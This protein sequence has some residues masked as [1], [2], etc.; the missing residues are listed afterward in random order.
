MIAYD[1]ET[2]NIAKGT[3]RPLYITAFGAQGFYVSASIDSMEHLCSIIIERF[4]IPEN[5]RCRFVA[6][7]GNNFDA[8][9]IGAAMLHSDEYEIRPYLTRSKALRGFRIVSK[10]D[11]KQNWEFLDGIAMTGLIGRKLDDFLAIFAPEFRKLKAP[12]W[13][14]GAKFDPNNA[15]HRRYAERD[16]E[17]LYWALLKAENIV[18]ETFGVPLQPTVGNMGIRIFQRNLPHG[19]K[20]WAPPLHVVEIIRDYAMRGG[21]CF[22]ARKYAGPVWKYDLNQAYAAAMRE[23]DLPT[24][25]VYMLAEYDDFFPVAI[26]RVT[27]FNPKNRIPFYY[28]AM[29][30]G[31][32]VFGLDG[33][34]ETWLTSI[35]VDQLLD[36]GW[37]VDVTEG[38]GWEFGFRMTEYVDRLEHLRM[39]A[40]GGPNGALGLL[41]KAVGNNSYGKTVEILDGI[42]MLLAKEQP[43]GFFSYQA[44]DEELRHIWC[45]FVD[46]LVREYHQ[47]QIGMCITAHVRMQ[48]RRAALVDPGA[49]LYAD[50]DCV[51][52]DRPVSLP[53]H[54]SQYGKWKIE[55]EGENYRLITKKVYADFAGT[56][57]HA[58][59]M[60]VRKLT[61]DDFL[62]WFEGEAPR[63]RQLHK[64]NFLKVMTGADMFVEHDKVGQRTGV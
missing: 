12:D 26:Y 51:I 24:G 31:K 43:D 35:E 41:V 46:P 55:A 22:C 63:Q 58:K 8:Y 38:Y 54:K 15:E 59:G 21:F 27:A 2:T 61:T 7:N 34:E 3:P 29:E 53:I 11:K 28:R 10:A 36:E 1:L 16:S 40:E 9:L 32:G 25:R 56:V 18:H 37:E 57:S 60:N 30:G 47:P 17:G 50:T 19:V 4:L 45:R 20:V 6:W 13:E 52:F 64:N 39:N 5:N 49:W 62:R 42:E 23:T 33:I 48:V 44:E 14:G